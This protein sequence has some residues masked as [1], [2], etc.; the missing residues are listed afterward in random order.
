MRVNFFN[1]LTTYA[2]FI[3]LFFYSKGRW[4]RENNNKKVSYKCQP[5]KRGKKSLVNLI[6]KVTCYSPFER[7]QGVKQIQEESSTVYQWKNSCTGGG[8]NSSVSK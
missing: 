2:F 8:Q 4:P 6:R 7:M 3:Y 5:P 1:I